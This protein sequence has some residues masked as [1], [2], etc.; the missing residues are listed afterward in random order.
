MAADYKYGLSWKIA[1]S[2]FS[3]AIL[4]FLLIPVVYIIVWS[5]TGGSGVVTLTNHFSFHWFI[6][7][8]SDESWLKAITTSVFYAI[9][10]TSIAL[11]L[12]LIYYYYSLWYRNYYQLVGYAMIVLPLFF[13][14]LVYALALKMLSARFLI[15]EPAS[16]ILGHISIIIPIQYFILEGSNEKINKDWLHSSIVMGAKH[17]EIV[18]KVVIPNIAISL[19]IAF[20]CGFLYSFDEIVISNFIIDTGN[21]TVPKKIWLDINRDINP[22]SAVVYSTLLVSSLLSILLINLFLI[23]KSTKAMRKVKKRT[24]VIFQDIR[25]TIFTGVVLAMV[26]VILE[27]YA[28]KHIAIWKVIISF[29]V[30]V[31]LYEILIRQIILIYIWGKEIIDKIYVY[32]KAEHSKYRELAIGLLS[33]KLDK[34]ISELHDFFH[35]KE[36]VSVTIPESEILSELLFERNRGFY[37]GTDSNVPSKFKELYPNYLISSQQ[38]KSSARILLCDKQELINDFTNNR[39]DFM[40]FYDWHIRH[41]VTILTVNKI[42]AYAIKTTLQLINSDIGIWDDD[43]VVIFKPEPPDKIHYWFKSHHTFEETKSYVRFFLNLLNEAK[44]IKVV[45]NNL[46]IESFNDNK[47]AEVNNKIKSLWNI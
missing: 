13:P 35:Q 16:I 46:Q 33:Y 2:I 45:N 10:S 28:Y 31:I 22:S 12:T 38:S 24:P 27:Y 8:Y 14:L 26:D 7:V 20:A 9:S 19:A 34:S 29:F 44:Q 15:P 36:G 6:K 18:R 43:Y 23:I 11:F 37:F 3:F 42:K 30:G 1:I 41:A 32:R 25:S 21:S 5:F 40:E 17:S 4:C 39:T 47:K